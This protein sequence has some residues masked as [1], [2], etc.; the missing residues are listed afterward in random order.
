LFVMLKTM[1]QE[2]WS[3]DLVY[4]G[5][6][7]KLTYTPDEAGNII[8]D[9]SQV[10]YRYGNESLPDVEMRVEVSPV[11]GDDGASIQAAIEALYNN[12]PNEKG[13][14]GAVVLKKGTYEIEGQLSISQSGIVLRGQGQ[15]ADGTV[16]I[17]TG[18][19]K[20]T[21]LEVGSAGGLSTDQSTK[22]SITEAYVPVGRKFVVVSST[23]GYAVGDEI[24]LYRPGTNN[25]ISD[26]KMDQISSTSNDPS[27]Q[28]SASSYNFYFERTISKVNG[29]TLFFRNPIIMA[30][31]KN[32]GGGFVYKSSFNRI[33]NVGIENICFKST[34]S[35]EDDEEH[36]WTAVEFKGVEHGWAKDI[37]SWYFAYACV[38]LGRESK[39]NTVLNCTCMDPKSIIT[40]SRRYSFYC[41]GQLNLF[42]GCATSEGRHDFVTG[43]RVCGPNVFTQCISRNG[44]SDIGPHHRWAMGTL[45]DAID[46]D[47][48]INVQ[49]RDD[50]GSGHGWAG[51]NQVF[52]NCKGSSSV[53]QSPWA[54]AKNYNIGFQG[55]KSTGARS[56]R[57][58][59]V[60]EGQNKTG[61]FPVSLY[62]AQLDQRLNNTTVFSVSSI[63]MELNDSTYQMNFN[64]PIDERLI[65]P[66]NFSI[67]GT[68][69]L[70]NL[71]FSVVLSDSYNVRFMFPNVGLLPSLSTLII[72]AQNIVSTNNDSLHGLSSS[73][74][75]IPD[76][77]PVVT[78]SNISVSNEEGSFVV[79][80]STKVGTVYLIRMGEP[81]KTREDFESAIENNKG[82][83]AEVVQVNV[84]VPIYTIGIYGGV[85][86]YYAID[87]DG[88]ISAAANEI[89]IIEQSGPITSNQLE[90]QATLKLKAN[91]NFLTV[92]PG[93]IHPYLLTLYDLYGRKLYQSKEMLGQQEI[94]L[95][96]N[97]QFQLI[98]KIVSDG[99]VSIKKVSIY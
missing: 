52:W 50:M 25:W 1:G 55:N 15:D 95:P 57:P 88:R 9:F 36:S 75:I 92:T 54:S 6:G 21:L 90:K 73:S 63:L 28:W 39:L 47:G 96:T 29:D 69:G 20:R 19:N 8:P 48:E 45:F 78:G 3:S 38:A 10:G 37:T 59:G 64:L 70:E 33:N 23:T 76:K 53:C 79:A 85:Y 7:G 68:S 35:S 87:E 2:S 93:S 17:A 83:K 61:L 99:K 58:D 16:L 65:V 13:F 97:H 67:S 89:A 26:I 81:N 24:A 42:K 77:R 74:Y 91:A 51:A 82:K 11:D 40:G 30:L 84:S 14:R 98:V 4:Y 31:D 94:Y 49:D 22:V 44:H 66:E 12:T 60:W 56:G 18:T 86:N 43:S 72:T 34:Y 46:T 71:D 80:K 62:E 27:T 41:E 32:Y 5:E